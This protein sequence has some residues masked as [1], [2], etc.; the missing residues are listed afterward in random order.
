MRDYFFQ[1]NKFCQQKDTRLCVC[2]YLHQ[3]KTELFFLDDSNGLIWVAYDKVV[4]GFDINTTEIKYRIDANKNGKIDAQD[5]NILRTKAQL[6]RLRGKKDKNK[7]IKEG[8]DRAVRA[9]E[10]IRRKEAQGKPVP[11]GLRRAALTATLKS[12]RS[13][14]KRK[15]R[16]AQISKNEHFRNLVQ[17]AVDNNVLFQHILADSWFGSKANMNFIH[18]NLNKHFIFAIKSNR[19]VALSNHQALRRHKRKALPLQHGPQG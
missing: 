13:I 14:T 18:H 15:K 1:R 17:L 5:L 6:I 12:S 19:C 10:S 8:I 11:E 9:D 4:I 3:K 7:E 2:K 16:K